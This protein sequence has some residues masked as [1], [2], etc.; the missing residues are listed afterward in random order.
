MR[1]DFPPDI[2]EL[3]GARLASGKYASEDDVLREALRV[4]SE[5]QE[6]LAAVQ[7]AIAEWRAGDDGVPLDGAIQSIRTKHNI[8]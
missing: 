1:Y 2:Q 8:S 3:V 7:D 5:E 4:L 6:D